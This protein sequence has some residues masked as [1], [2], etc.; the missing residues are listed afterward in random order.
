MDVTYNCAVRTKDKTYKYID[1]LNF[2]AD[3][4]INLDVRADKIWLDFSIADA[5]V[6]N[7]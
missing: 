2:V 6:L 7:L 5:E 1:V 4:R 3:T